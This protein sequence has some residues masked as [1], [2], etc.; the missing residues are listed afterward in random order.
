MGIYRLTQLITI[1]ELVRRYIPIY[2]IYDYLKHNGNV[3]LKYKEAP[4]YYYYY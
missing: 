1:F 3:L 2:Y 4:I